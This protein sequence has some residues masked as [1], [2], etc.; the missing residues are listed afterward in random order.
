MEH[1]FPGASTLTILFK[2]ADDIFDD[3]IGQV[4]VDLEERFYNEKYRQ[5]VD[6]PIETRDIIDENTD[7]V[8]GTVRMWV[9]IFRNETKK[10]QKINDLDTVNEGEKQSGGDKKIDVQSKSEAIPAAMKRSKRVWDISSI[11]VQ[12]MELRVIV[13][14]TNDVPNNDP[15][16]MSDIYVQVMF[17]GDTDVEK[18]TDTHIR[19]CN[20][21]VFF[22]LPKN[23]GFFQLATCFSSQGR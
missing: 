21:F 4:T 16:D 2:E 7:M 13:W 6:V 22:F 10:Q 12:T 19:A 18:R 14:E 1:E 3:Y 5:L 17:R 9:D 23:L 20:G 8:V 15:E 11:P